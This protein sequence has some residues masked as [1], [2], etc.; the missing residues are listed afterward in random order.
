MKKKIK[1]GLSLRYS[2][3][4]LGSWRHPDVNPGGLRNSN[5]L[6]AAKCGGGCQIR[7]VF[8]ADGVGIRSMDEPRGS[9]ARSRQNVELEPLT[10]LSVSAPVT[11]NIG[12]VA[13]ASTTYNEPTMLLESTGRSIRSAAGV[14]D[15]TLSRHGLIKR[16]GNLQSRQTLGLRYPL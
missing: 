3:Y 7:Q 2:G 5:V 11:N 16:L 13:T 9:L 1:L 15:G 4:H 14:P 8:L 10:S 6:E 12:L